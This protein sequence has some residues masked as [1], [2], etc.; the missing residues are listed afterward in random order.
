MM[1]LESYRIFLLTA[2]TGN[3]TKAA[4]ALHITQPSVSYA[5]KQ[6]EEH[7]GAKL[8]DRLSKGVRLTEEG[9]ALYEYVEQSF[10]LLSR[11]EKK[12]RELVQLDAGELRIGA[13]GPI[14]KHVLLPH[15]GKFHAE[16]PQIRI[17]LMQ[18]KTSEV[19]RQ[20]QE[21]QID[22]GLVHL[23][24]EEDTLDVTPFIEIQ[25]CF[26]VGKAYKELAEH[27][28]TVRELTQIPLLLPTSG[29][30]TRLFV[31]HWFAERG[32]YKEPDI[33]LTSTEMIVEFAQQGYGAAFVA[34]QFAQREL[35][36]GSLCE[37]QLTD[38]IPPR[39]IGIVTRKNK[40]LPSAS[41]S[42]LS[43]LMKG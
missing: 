37:L 29:S 14:I 30:S 5:I 17:R 6:L 4:Q 21:E 25:D 8:F 19:T 28:L 23:P 43:L 7:F 26:V 24:L 42:F 18:I 39:M 3:F 20:L 36:E 16:H 22:L 41:S 32:I 40:V 15:L 2:R 35:A 13:S 38:P 34:R 33:E 27:P 12:L 11:G 31:E 1:H 10:S 9:R